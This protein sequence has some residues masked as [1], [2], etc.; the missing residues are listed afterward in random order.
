VVNKVHDACKKAMDEPEFEAVL[1]KFDMT[2]AY[3]NPEDSEKEF[4]QLFDR[5]GKIVQKLGLQKKP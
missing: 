3:L 2:T 1:K 5:V 4:R